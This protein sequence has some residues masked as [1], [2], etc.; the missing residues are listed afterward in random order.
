MAPNSL[1]S[2]VAN[3]P[4]PSDTFRDDHD[5][6]ILL[7][8][9]GTGPADRD[10]AAL[11]N[12]YARFDPADRAQG[13]PPL[14]GDACKRWLDRVLTGINVLAW[15]K[16]RVVG[17][18]ALLADGEGSHELV[19]FVDQ[20]YQGAGV[21]SALLGALLQAGHEHDVERVRLSVEWANQAAVGL[22]RKFGFEVVEKTPMELEMAREL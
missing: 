1:H 7:A 22:Y 5:R 15:H 2:S 14:P 4:A 3:S 6:R 8:E 9:Y 21:G 17:H 20:P 16:D 10:R 13:L 11:V 18:A 12:M 19:V